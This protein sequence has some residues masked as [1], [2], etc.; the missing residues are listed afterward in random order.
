VSSRA[1]EKARLREEREAREQQEDAAARKRKQRL[2]ILA[3]V[4]GA[5][6]VVVVALILLGGGGDDSP[7]G[8]G[9]GSGSAVVG[10]A[11][12][13]DLLKGIPQKGE[14]LGKA[15]APVTLVQYVDL[16]CPFCRE[17]STGALPELIRK[18]V[19]TGKVKIEQ[20]T[21]RILGADSEQAASWAAAA[22]QRNRLFQ[23]SEVFYR[24]QGEENTGYV[25]S[26][27][28]TKIAKGAGLDATTMAARARTPAAEDLIVANERSANTLGV[29]STP[30]FALGRT[31][32]TLSALNVSQ[33]DV[34]EFTGPIDKLLGQ[35]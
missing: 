28:L 13:D 2:G 6:V 32:Q 15:N 30:S 21:L 29:S 34:S 23:F 9:G 22:Q 31:G 26:G 19:R 20:R 18:Y 1:E 16:Q 10:A 27:Y 33:L 8:A 12:V 24:N 14:T 35:S 3:G 7:K 25:T 17:Y 4:A 5:A 11:S